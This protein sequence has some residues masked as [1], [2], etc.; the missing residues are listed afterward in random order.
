[1][2]GII[3]KIVYMIIF[4]VACMGTKY[5]YDYVVKQEELYKM[6]QPQF[7]KTIAEDMHDIASS[8]QLTVTQACELIAD[9]GK[10]FATEMH[11]S[12]SQPVV[13]QVLTKG[14]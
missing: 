4:A 5:G 13:Y 10:E 2:N 14:Q 3:S 7:R 1:M 8:Q 9:N 12:K 6:L 11:I